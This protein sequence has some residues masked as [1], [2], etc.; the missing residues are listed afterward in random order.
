MLNFCCYFLEIM[1][2]HEQ[3]KKSDFIVSKKE[4]SS[5]HSSLQYGIGFIDFAH[6]SSLFLRRNNGNLALKNTTQRE[7][8]SKFVKSNIYVQDPRKVKYQLSDCERFNFPFTT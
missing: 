6:V 7:K 5:T 8:L 3:S 2:L 4:F 1:N